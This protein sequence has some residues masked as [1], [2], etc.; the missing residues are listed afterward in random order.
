V[1][2]K[3]D[4]D[5]GIGFEEMDEQEKEEEMPPRKKRKVEI[6]QEDEE[7]EKDEEDE[8][9]E[10]DQEDEEEEKDQEK[11]KR[12]GKQ[13][14]KCDSSYSEPTEEYPQQIQ[15]VPPV[16]SS[17]AIPVQVTPLNKKQVTSSKHLCKMSHAS[18]LSVKKK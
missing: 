17:Q 14:V 15:E 12:K 8:E 10:K 13:V 7:D 16:T 5:E 9:E 2:K 18:R 4:N 11:L 6:E 3:D 1:D